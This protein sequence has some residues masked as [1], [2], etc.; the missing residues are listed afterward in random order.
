MADSVRF[1]MQRHDDAVSEGRGLRQAAEAGGNPRTV[2]LGEA[3]RLFQRAARRNRQHD[4][5][6]RCLNPQRVASR[7]AMTAEPD[8]KN[9]AIERD[10]DPRWLTRSAIEQHL[11]RHRAPRIQSQGRYCHIAGI[12]GEMWPE[13]RGRSGAAPLPDTRTFFAPFFA[14]FLGRRAARSDNVIDSTK[15]EMR[16]AISARKRE[17]LN[18]P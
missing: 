15:S 14:P 3:A 9:H 4:F 2:L 18:T 12:S 6:A 10:L 8:G 16:G 7:L 17:P 11:R 1:A 5:T 13:G